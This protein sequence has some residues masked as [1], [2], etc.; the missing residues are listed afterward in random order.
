MSV[1]NFKKNASAWFCFNKLLQKELNQVRERWNTHHI[2]LSCHNTQAGI[3]EQM[4]FIPKSYGT[5]DFK[6]AISHDDIIEM[7]NSVTVTVANV[8][9]EYFTE[10]MDAMNQHH[11]ENWREG[12]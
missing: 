9:E 8:Y 7:Q 2:R 6:V 12:A 11:P 3:P 10:V 1:M 4:Y 5:E